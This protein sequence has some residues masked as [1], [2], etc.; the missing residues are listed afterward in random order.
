MNGC[1]I[2][3]CTVAMA[4]PNS[5]ADMRHRPYSWRR[6]VRRCS[7]PPRG[8]ALFPFPHE[9][10]G[11]SGDARAL[12]Y[13]ALWATLAIG[14][15]ARRYRTGLRDLPRGARAA[16]SRF[17]GP[18]ARALRLPALHLRHALSARRTLLRYQTS[19]EMTP[20]ANKAG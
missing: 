20:S 1:S 12:R 5:E 16:C 18:A 2:V 9:G 15:P 19:L 10:N 14:Q 11:A 6:R 7:P 17:A 8:Q 3:R 13:G 4:G